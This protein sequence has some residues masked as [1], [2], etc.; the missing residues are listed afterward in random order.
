MRY[1]GGVG[2]WYED[3]KLLCGVFVALDVEACAGIDFDVF[4]V[5][6]EEG[7]FDLVAG[8]EGGVF[9][10]FVDGITSEAGFGVGDL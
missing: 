8:F 4:L 7:Y 3:L 9:E 6:D 1:W 10:C 5:V 2:E